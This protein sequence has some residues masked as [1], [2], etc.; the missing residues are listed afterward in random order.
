MKNW[1]LI[2][3]DEPDSAKWWRNSCEAITRASYPFLVPRGGHW[4]PIV[5]GSGVV[6]GA[7]NGGGMG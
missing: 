5:G 7:G 4:A 1:L 3:D 6:R 2:T